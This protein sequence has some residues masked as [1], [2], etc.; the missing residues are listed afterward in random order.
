MAHTA[1]EHFKLILGLKIA[2]LAAE[3]AHAR[4]TAEA[5]AEQLAALKTG[6]TK[7]P[8]PPPKKDAAP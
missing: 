8:R 2:E 7:T 1:D 4:A 6:K 5:L 3:L